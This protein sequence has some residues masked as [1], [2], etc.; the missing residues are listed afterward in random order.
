[1]R[2]IVNKNLD[3]PYDNYALA[4]C[5]KDDLFYINAINVT[6]PGNVPRNDFTIAKSKNIEE[7]EELIL[8]ISTAYNNKC[9]RYF[10]NG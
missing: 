9:V 2:I 10:V 8:D 7:L 4:I 3:F 1:M 5:K 6:V